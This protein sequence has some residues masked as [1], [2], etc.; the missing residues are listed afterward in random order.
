MSEFNVGDRVV[1]ESTDSFNDETGVIARIEGASLPYGVV[2]DNF[3]YTTP[4]DTDDW[5]DAG[6]TWFNE[7]EL[8]LE[9]I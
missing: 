9:E 1:I 8:S 5:F 2:V 4:P 3:E 6:V 7:N